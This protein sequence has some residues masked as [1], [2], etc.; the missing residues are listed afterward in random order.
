MSER[1]TVIFE[2]DTYVGLENS[3]SAVRASLGSQTPILAIADT[4]LVDDLRV[5]GWARDF[6]SLM[7]KD[8]DFASF[9]ALV[10]TPFVMVVP[11]SNFQTLCG[12]P[13]AIELLERNLN[14][15]QIGGFIA[16]SDLR[17][18]SGAY[19][20]APRLISGALGLVPLEATS[21]LWQMEGSFAST[22]VQNLGGLVMMRTESLNPGHVHFGSIPARAVSWVRKDEEDR[23]LLFSGFLAAV[24]TGR[25]SKLFEFQGF[26]N[27][28]S[29]SFSAWDSQNR[30]QV[31][32][33][34][35]GYAVK[36]D[37]IES[38]LFFHD[39]RRRVADGEEAG[40]PFDPCSYYLT[41]LNTAQMGPGFQNFLEL[42]NTSAL[43]PPHSFSKF[44]GF[45]LRLARALEVH[46]SP[47]TRRIVK[48]MV[49]QFS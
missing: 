1:I 12:V 4:S 15:H 45:V 18:H 30:Q 49:R 29:Q 34:H 26:E 7:I 46:V 43:E 2:A 17:V 47:S 38:I 22:R 6:A 40:R 36:N 13:L 32:I 10:T 14:L 48:R 28:P 39:R 41:D 31:T 33:M 3:I 19:V 21:P 25:D 23:A 11:L 44:E 27:L 35:Q 8:S 20:H 9:K 16:G 24:T 37:A 42:F 5:S